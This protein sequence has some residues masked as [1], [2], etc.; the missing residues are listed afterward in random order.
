[1]GLSLILIFINKIAYTTLSCMRT[2][3]S[4]A[5]HG[6]HTSAGMTNAIPK[7]TYDFSAET[8]ICIRLTIL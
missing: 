6:T 1:M 4:T 2:L 7:Y 8:R 5:L 3:K